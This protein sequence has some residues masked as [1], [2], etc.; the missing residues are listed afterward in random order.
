MIDTLSREIPIVPR[1][2]AL[3]LIVVQNYSARTDGGEHRAQGVTAAS[4]FS[5]LP[6]AITSVSR[7]KIFKK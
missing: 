6:C 2:A 4:L 3:L 1:K 5:I 7:I